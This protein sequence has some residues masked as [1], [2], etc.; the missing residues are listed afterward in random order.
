MRCLRWRSASARCSR[1]VLGQRRGE[2]LDRDPT[3]HREP[4][5]DAM[6]A[7]AREVLGGRGQAGVEV[8]GRDAPARAL[9]LVAVACD[10]DDGPRVALDET[11]GDDPDHALVP[12]GIVR[13]RMPAA[14]ATPRRP[15]RPARTAA[16]RIPSSTAWR[17]RFSASSRSASARARPS[18]AV[19]RSS[20]AWSGWHSRPAALIRG[21]SRN[22]TS[23]DEAWRAIDARHRHQRPQAGLR[24]AP[25]PA[26]A[27]A[28]EAAV[29]VAE[30]H[31]VGDRRESDQVEVELELGR[32]AAGPRVQGLGQL[33]HDAGAAQLGERILGRVGCTRACTRAARRPAGGGR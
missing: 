12:V 21:A 1:R 30:R 27:R 23:V 11:R 26:Q 33:E 6:P 17:S 2:G 29:L 31:D 14:R 9:R 8:V 24:R 20:S 7:V 19:S 28:H 13:A 10:Q 4:G 15:P 22:P 3:A 5:G 18:S 16:R 25:Q 32:V